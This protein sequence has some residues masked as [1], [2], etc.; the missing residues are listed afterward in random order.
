MTPKKDS[1]TM[2]ITLDPNP[3]GK[4]KRLG[5]SLADDWNMRLL[6]VVAG[7]LPDVAQL[8][9]ADEG[10]LSMFR[11]GWAQPSELRTITLCFNHGH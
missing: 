8:M 11:R 7:A 1:Q 9:A 2:A 3:K 4:F 10:A 6:N 5:G